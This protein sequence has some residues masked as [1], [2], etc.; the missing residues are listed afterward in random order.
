[1]KILIITSNNYPTANFE[2]MIRQAGHTPETVNFGLS[3]DSIISRGTPFEMPL[4]IF[5]HGTSGYNNHGNVLKELNKLGYA[6]ATTMTANYPTLSDSANVVLGLLREGYS[7]SMFN[8][9]ATLTLKTF[10]NDILINSQGMEEGTLLQVRQSGA[11][12][13]SVFI[14]SNQTSEFYVPLAVHPGYENRYCFGYLP[15]QTNTGTYITQAPV[16]HL[17]FMFESMSLKTSDILKDVIDF[18]ILNN[19]PPYIIKG[20]VF[21][22][23]NQPLQRMLRVYKQST[24]SLIT[25]L[26]SDS[27]GFYSYRLISSDKVFIVCFSGSDTSN[28]QIYTNI[29][30]SEVIEGNEVQNIVI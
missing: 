10:Q 30:P 13:W 8:S 22:S 5:R 19:L 23:N 15:K 27:S 29:I 9:P 20:Y 26:Q 3:L 4:I 24:G 7:D 2:D 1:M 17:G 12:A 25:T 21:D 11:N 6:V 16:F 28:G 18:A 14:D